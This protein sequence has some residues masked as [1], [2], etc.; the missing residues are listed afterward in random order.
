MTAHPYQPLAEWTLF[1]LC[2]IQEIMDS[3]RMGTVARL[4]ANPY[5]KPKQTFVW[6]YLVYGEVDSIGFLK[7]GL[8]AGRNPLDR[9]K[10]LYKRVVEA[11]KVPS[12][13]A[14]LHDT[15]AVILLNLYSDIESFCSR[16]KTTF[17]GYTESFFGDEQEVARVFRLAYHRVEKWSSK[18][19]ELQATAELNLLQSII[20]NQTIK[21]QSDSRRRKEGI[22]MLREHLYDSVYFYKSLPH[23]WLDP[24]M[25][26]YGMP[27]PAPPAFYLAMVR[28]RL[29]IPPNQE[30][31]ALLQEFKQ[32]LFMYSKLK[33]GPKRSECYS[34]IHRLL[35][36]KRNYKI[37]ECL[38]LDHIETFADILAVF[39]SQDSS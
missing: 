20:W 16:H 11:F 1:S 28:N 6:H 21:K 32:E 29:K 17:D 2:E 9:N 27:R 14:R 4:G 8:Y 37:N 23:E 33:Q 22:R 19:H 35:K 5:Q 25:E 34:E 38:V 15:I 36:R 3:P 18:H 31:L 24:L 10:K 26:A 30:D 7:T 39:H 13:L 12:S